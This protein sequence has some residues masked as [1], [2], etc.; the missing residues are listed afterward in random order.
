MSDFLG[1]PIAPGYKDFTTGTGTQNM[2]WQFSRKFI[3]KWYPKS[4]LTYTSNTDFEGDLKQSGDTVIIPTLSNVTVRDAVAGGS[5]IWETLASDPITFR[6][7]RMTEWAF[8]MDTVTLRQFLQKDI[9]DKY[10]KDAVEQTRLRVDS[11]YLASIYLDA[12]AHN[13][14]TTAGKNAGAYNLGTTTTP[15]SLTRANI[16]NNIMQAEAVLNEQDVP[17][18]GRW[19]VLPTVARY[20]VDTSE[21]KDASLTGKSQSNL[22][23]RGGYVGMI[24]RFKVYESN[25]YSA[26]TDTGKTCFNILFGHKYAVT[27]AVE[28]ID[29]V[30]FDKFENGY[31]KG[32]KGRQ[33]YD[34]KTIKPQGLGVLYATVA[35]LV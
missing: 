22:V 24:G 8:R 30:Y 1:V 26:V 7:N 32:M 20:L 4:V 34:W 19:I 29:S 25:L 15:V 16:V 3:E 28:V 31:G 5:T 23:D 10:A 6:V 11:Q 33:L 18:E 12:D 17:E 13:I 9:M 35:T 21:L 2:P 14:G 27:S